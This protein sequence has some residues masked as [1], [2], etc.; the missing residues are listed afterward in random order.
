MA[1]PTT[2]V[3]AVD[4]RGDRVLTRRRIEQLRAVGAIPAAITRRWFQHMGPM[5][6]LDELFDETAPAQP[7]MIDL[8]V[9]F[10][11]S[12]SLWGICVVH[13]EPDWHIEKRALGWIVWKD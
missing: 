8:P 9:W 12:D 2:A 4:T 3:D 5:D 1:D 7:E 10:A 13:V 11:K 6:A